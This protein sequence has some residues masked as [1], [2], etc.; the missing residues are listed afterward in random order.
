MPILNDSPTL[1]PSGRSLLEIELAFCYLVSHSSGGLVSR[2]CSLRT[3]IHDSLT[4]IP[5]LAGTDLDFY[6]T[7]LSLESASSFPFLFSC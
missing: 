3:N 1:A 5:R 7:L 6:L 2:E 4:L